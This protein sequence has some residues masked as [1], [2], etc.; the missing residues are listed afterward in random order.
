M[1]QKHTMPVEAGSTQSGRGQLC[2]EAAVVGGQAAAAHWQSCMA[3]M[4]RPH[5][6]TL[7]GAYR[8]LRD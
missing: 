4:V 5:R 7:R 2:F 3:V 8:C 6:R 1:M